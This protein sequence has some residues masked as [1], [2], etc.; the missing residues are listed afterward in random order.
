MSNINIDISS[1][2]NNRNNLSQIELQINSNLNKKFKI[3]KYLGNGTY[4]D[5]Y[6]GINTKNNKKYVIKIIK[7][8]DKSKTDKIITELGF[9]KLLNKFPSSKKYVNPCSDFIVLE[10]S[11]IAIFPVLKGNNLDKIYETMKDLNPSE[12]YYFTKIIMKHLLLGLEYI[13]GKNISHQ[14]LSENNIVVYFPTSKNKNT[15]S[16]N[17]P[18]NSNNNTTNNNTTN[19]NTTNNSNNIYGK[20]KNIIDLKFVN[21]STGCGDYIPIKDDDVYNKS[22]KDISMK[23]SHHGTISSSEV[24]K[25]L[26]KLSKSANSKSKYFHLAKKKDVRDLGIVFWRLINNDNINKYQNNDLTPN[27]N[28][29]FTRYNDY[30]DYKGNIKMKHLHDYV[31]KYMLCPMEKRLSSKR[32][33]QKFVAFDKYQGND[34]V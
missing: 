30:V 19:N 8:S 20:Y 27:D 17:I 9:I 15:I 25:Y 11:I 13:H 26:N 32:L 10:N 3:D 16:N 31:I 28:M 18:H 34:V 5:I 7:K 2:K 33:L 23:L 12:R 1:D 22:C 4:G 24:T 21:F 14:N 29:Y 6:K